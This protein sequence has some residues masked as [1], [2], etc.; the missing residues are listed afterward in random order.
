[1]AKT[2][3]SDHDKTLTVNGVAYRVRYYNDRVVVCDTDKLKG[4]F[5]D[6]YPMSW[7]DTQIH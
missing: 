2:I 6:E 3:L 7:V 5:G 4:K 1:M